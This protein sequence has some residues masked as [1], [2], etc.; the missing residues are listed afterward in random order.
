MEM[1][2]IKMLVDRLFI[3]KEESNVLISHWDDCLK[4]EEHFNDANGD[5]EST[6]LIL[7]PQEK[8]ALI[9]YLIDKKI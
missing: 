9:K 2:E 1:S 7:N 6:L 5:Q 3:K 4:I 8:Q